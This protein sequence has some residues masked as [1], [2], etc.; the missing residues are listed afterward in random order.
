MVESK[1]KEDRVVN[2]F[3]LLVCS[4]STI[5]C[6]A[7]PMGSSSNSHV[8]FATSQSSLVR[9]Q[10]PRRKKILTTHSREICLYVAGMEKENPKTYWLMRR[11]SM[12]SRSK[13]S[14]YG[15]AS[16]PSLPV[17]IPASSCEAVS[18]AFDIALWITS[19]HNS[20][21]FVLYDV[22]GAAN[23]L[24]TTKSYKGELV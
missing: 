20:F 8:T 24:T 7:M 19:Y 18:Q 1:H 14:K 15:M 13:V 6:L 2:R 21:A 3:V 10:N 23:L 11:I 5:D 22:T 16:V 17:C 9:V 12:V 4:N